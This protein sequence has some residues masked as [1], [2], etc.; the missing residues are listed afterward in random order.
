M[1]SFFKKKSNVVNTTQPVNVVPETV[2]IEREN[3]IADETY[4]SNLYFYTILKGIVQVD[5]TENKLI[6]LQNEVKKAKEL[7]INDYTGFQNY[8]IG[9]GIVK[10]E[11]KKFDNFI[12]L[13]NLIDSDNITAWVSMI[14]VAIDLILF[15]D[16]ILQESKAYVLDKR[17]E[18]ENIIEDKLSLEYD[19]SN[20]SLP[21][22]QK[23]ISS[24]LVGAL[25]N[26]ER[27]SEFVLSNSNKTVKAINTKLKSLVDNYNINCNNML[28]LIVDE[29]VSQSI[30]ST[31][32][33]SYEERV[34]LSLNGKV[35]DLSTHSH[36][37]IVS[38]MEY[39]FTFTVNGKKAGVSAKR[40]LRER[41]K[42]NHEDI[43]VLD[44]D[45]VFLITLGTDLNKEKLESVLEKNG[46]YVVV[47]DEIYNTHSYLNTN[48]RVIS[49]K[50]LTKEN[51]ERIIK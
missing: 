25:T 15:K 44:V 26:L 51:L 32:G 36:D 9:T 6:T 18:T 17:K 29:S 27:Q 22:G 12:N 5:L 31:A 1:I 47:A 48:P 20:L 10:E 42:Q 49:S 13:I 50:D 7:Y 34:R 8:I 21:Y 4:E 37:S 39:D 30:K 16:L 33:S 24:L 23:V 41:Y 46:L 11:Q 38:A 35:E 28:L 43:D 2:Y 40:T 45:Y 14:D 3:K 19:T